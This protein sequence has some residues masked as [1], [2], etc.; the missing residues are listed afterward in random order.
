MNP[1]RR[2]ITAIGSTLAVAALNAPTASA[3]PPTR[4][5]F[6]SKATRSTPT[7]VPS[8]FAFK[9]RERS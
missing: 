2:I 5:V 1:T 8:H 9:T 6:P 4:E 3:A 7:C